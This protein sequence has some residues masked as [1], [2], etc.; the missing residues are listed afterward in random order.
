MSSATNI[1]S[2]EN[3]GQITYANATMQD[4]AGRGILRYELP[5]AKIIMLVLRAYCVDAKARRIAPELVNPCAVGQNGADWH[6]SCMDEL[7]GYLSLQAQ[8]IIVPN[9]LRLATAG[10]YYVKPKNYLNY[11]LLQIVS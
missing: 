3:E 1:V 11:E 6:P 4:M 9:Y 10:G 7:C 2:W 8:W 5:L